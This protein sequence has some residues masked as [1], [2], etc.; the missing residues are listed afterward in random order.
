[1]IELKNISL[2][3]GATMAL[4]DVSLTIEPR[5]L[6]SIIGPNGAGKSS[7]LSVISRMQKP[8]SGEVCINGESIF[9]TDPNVLAKRLSIL[10]QDNHLSARIRVDEL[11]CFGRF[12]YHKGRPLPDDWAT[13][14][15]AIEQL[16][17]NAYK[18]RYLDQLS[19]GQRQRAYIAMIVAQDTPYVFLDEPLN[20]LD[21]K[22]SVAIMKHLRRA[23][24]D[25]NKSIT[26]VLHDINFASTYSDQIITMKQGRVTAKGT[27][28]EIMQDEIL[29]SLY[30]MPLT[31]QTITGHPLCLYYS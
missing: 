12:P 17:L 9:K 26:V 29:T 31:V 14:H 10:R 19:G 6:T 30:E 18:H 22:N 3:H 23:C 1:M 13:V 5:G 27:P 4:D 28:S 2:R 16:D 24:D 15:R 21:M 8:T 25:F 11:V 7:L 20:N